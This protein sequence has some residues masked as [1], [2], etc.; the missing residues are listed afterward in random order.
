MR[1]LFT[2][3]QKMLGVELRPPWYLGNAAPRALKVADV[4]QAADELVE[5]KADLWEFINTIA[6]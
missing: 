6:R 5:A 3:D 2:S 1:R 4:R